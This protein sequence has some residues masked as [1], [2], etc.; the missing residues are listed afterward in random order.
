MCD[1]ERVVQISA[2]YLCAGTGERDM[3]RDEQ[4]K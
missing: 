4:G 2:G 3:L 1:S